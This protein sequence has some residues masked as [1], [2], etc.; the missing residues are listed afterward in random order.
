M[1]ALDLLINRYS[2][3]SKQLTTPAP[4]AADLRTMLR[5]AV[6]APD[7]G[8]LKPWH[9]IIIKNKQRS[10]L[11]K[12]LAQ[13]YAAENPQATA[14]M[15]EKVAQKPQRAPMIIC[16]VAKTNPAHRKVP[17]LE[18]IITAAIAGQHL[19][20]AAQAL[21]YDSIWL[22]GSSCRHPIVTTA[23]GLGENDK[24]LGYIYVGKAVKTPKAPTRM[25]IEQCSSYW[26]TGDDN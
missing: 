2:A 20:L 21:N 3:S 17:V 26:E 4:T 16:V 12:L 15:L 8:A 19:Q 7:H 10:A 25:A 1:Q 24:L 13:V 11:G 23:L 14:S 6:S 18:Q 5:A 9:F 22:S